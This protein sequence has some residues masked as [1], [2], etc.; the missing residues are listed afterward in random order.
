MLHFCMEI[1]ELEPSSRLETLLCDA[2]VRII[3]EIR[4][5]IQG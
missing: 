1:P 4:L 5:L 2:F 3:V